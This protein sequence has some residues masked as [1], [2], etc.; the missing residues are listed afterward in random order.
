MG[1]VDVDAAQQKRMVKFVGNP[2][3]AYEY[4]VPPRDRHLE[5]LL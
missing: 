3:V 1:N 5:P 4:K 2:V